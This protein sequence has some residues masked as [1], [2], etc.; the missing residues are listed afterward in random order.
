MRSFILL[1]VL[2]IL[3][4]I[5]A[6]KYQPDFDEGLDQSPQARARRLNDSAIMLLNADK[7]AN[8]NAALVAFDQAIQLD[9]AYDKSYYN[10][11]G[12]LIETKQYPSAILLCNQLYAFYP[13]NSGLLATEGMLRIYN[14][15][16][17]N[18]QENFSM[19]LTLLKGNETE[20]IKLKMFILRAQGNE[21]ANDLRNQLKEK[22]IYF[23]EA[24]W[25]TRHQWLVEAWRSIRYFE[26]QANQ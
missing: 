3:L 12:L 13:Q 19:A 2:T 17:L 9:S 20:E 24:V 6:C 8:A 26:S 14:Q 23:S 16:S 25:N 1:P 11:L 15:D 5:G 21:G 10:K 22:Q 7:V 18:A 4:S